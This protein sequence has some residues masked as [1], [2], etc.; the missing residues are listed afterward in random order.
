[1]P[2]AR[3]RI[4][5][6]R[7]RRFLDLLGLTANVEFSA[8]AAGLTSM[9]AY[10]LRRRDGRFRRAWALALEEGLAASRARS[11]GARWRARRSQSPT[12][13]RWSGTRSAIRT[14]C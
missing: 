7:R 13:A 1:M 12:R 14:G 3:H 6:A 2:S 9:T 10:R 11:I 4:D 8:K 5:A